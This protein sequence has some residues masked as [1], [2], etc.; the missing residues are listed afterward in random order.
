MRVVTPDPLVQGSIDIQEF[1][2]GPGDAVVPVPA[3]AWLLG[4]AVAG[5][6][7]LRRRQARD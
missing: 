2:I 6:G 4:S 1:L 7:V 3:A 5:L